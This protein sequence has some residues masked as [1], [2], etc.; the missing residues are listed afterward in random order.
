[1]FR[2]TLLFSLSFLFFSLNAQQNVDK[3]TEW[4]KFRTEIGKFSVVVPG[5]LIEKSDSSNTPLGSLKMHTFY[6]QPE[7][8][9]GNANFMYMVQYC[10]YPEGTL[11]GNDTTFT[12]DFFESTRNEAAFSIN[13]KVIYHTPVTLKDFQGQFWRIHYKKDSAVIKTKAYIVKNRYYAIQTITFKALASNMDTDKFFD[14]FQILE[15]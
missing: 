14:S 7:A 8:N 9:S 5:E 4:N 11:E 2:I 1:M 3:K 15:H 10:D 6:H 12:N 13:G